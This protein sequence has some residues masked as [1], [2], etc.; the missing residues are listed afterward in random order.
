MTGESSIYDLDN[1][2]T[3]VDRVYSA[4]LIMHQ[5]TMQGHYRNGFFNSLFAQEGVTEPT[6][7]YNYL[8]IGD[9]LYLVY[10]YHICSG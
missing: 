9:D 8:P 6:A 5:L 2:P 10:W 4:D 1:I 7:G 3:W